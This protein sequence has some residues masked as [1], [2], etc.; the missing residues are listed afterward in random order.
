MLFPEEI[1][2][3]FLSHPLARDVHAK[4]GRYGLAL[5]TL[6]HS[7]QCLSA[8]S[9]CLELRSFEIGN[10]SW[11][12]PRHLTHHCAPYEEAPVVTLIQLHLHQTVCVD[13]E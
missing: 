1:N 6:I 12:P 5:M 9:A 13:S 4:D 2:Q 3:R 10:A 8:M 7:H 11:T